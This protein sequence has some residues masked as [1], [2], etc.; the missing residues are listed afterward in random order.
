MAVRTLA[1]SDLVSEIVV[2]D[3]NVAGAERFA[4]KV[5]DKASAREADAAD[6]EGMATLM[7]EGDIV[8]NTSGPFFKFGMPALR[9][10]IR[11]GKNYCD[12][13][14]DWRPTQEMLDLD[15]E[16]K[17]AGI[18]AIVGIGASPGVSNL[19][20]KHAAAQLEQVDTVQ[21]CWAVGGGEVGTAEGAGGAAEGELAALEH[22]MYSASGKI[23]TFRDGDWVEIDS[24]ESGEDVSFPGMGPYTV[25]HIGHPEPVTLPRYIPGVKTVSNL[26]ALYPPQ[27]NDLVREQARRVTA[28]EID[29]RAAALAFVATVA[30]DPQKWLVG[31]PAGIGGGL[32]ATARG[33]K[34]GRP[35]RYT[36]T[37]AGMPGGG[38]A[39][40]TGLPLA[41]AALQVLRG[42]IKERGVLPP[43]ACIDPLPFFEECKAFW[44]I[45]LGDG[46]LVESWEDAE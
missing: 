14:D 29:A 28:G 37:V 22:M 9:A 46:L 45:R 11:A 35:V 12:I 15:G 40:A 33:L 36:C 5:G 20:A 27:L 32:C 7:A 19:L 23:P 3:K 31:S 25:Y 24:F 16:A 17:A 39:G 21:T 42:E 26:G 30:S 2:A 6:E 10:A 38:M 44:T 18:T 13:N 8:I 1:A 41:T 4:A 34:E 43:E